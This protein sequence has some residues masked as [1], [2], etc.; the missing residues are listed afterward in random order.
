[1]KSR[2]KKKLKKIILNYWV[3]RNKVLALDF[4]GESIRL[5][6]KAALRY[7]AIPHMTNRKMSVELAE[8]LDKYGPPR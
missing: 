7:R 1:M 4:S 6:R 3:A 8:E 5:L 2:Q